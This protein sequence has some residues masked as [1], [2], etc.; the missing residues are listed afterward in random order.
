MNSKE[1]ARKKR[2]EE[3]IEIIKESKI[4]GESF[5]KKEV[6]L[7]LMNRYNVAQRTATEYYEQASFANVH[8]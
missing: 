4:S 2:I 3:I 5:K 6:I 1:F 8:T 7:A